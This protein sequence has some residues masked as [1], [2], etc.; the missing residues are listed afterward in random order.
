[1]TGED[2]SGEPPSEDD[3][4]TSDTKGLRKNAEPRRYFIP[5]SEVPPVAFDSVRRYFCYPGQGLE[6][7]VIWFIRDCDKENASA[8]QDKYKHLTRYSVTLVKLL[9]TNQLIAVGE[10]AN[11]NKSILPAFFWLDNL[12][13]CFGSNYD[14]VATIVNEK[15]SEKIRIVTIYDPTTAPGLPDQPHNNTDSLEI[16][17]NESE[18][19]KIRNPRGAG[20]K[21]K[22]DWDEA[23]DLFIEQIALTLDRPLSLESAYKDYFIPL[24]ISKSI[25][26]VSDKA[27]KERL[28]EK[29]PLLYHNIKVNRNKVS[30]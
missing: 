25:E 10:N 22:I 23:L 7:S 4:Q 8:Y 19:V 28:L 17:Q 1:M 20:A 21:P 30:K 12:H 13:I 26:L 29:F 16:S 24:C 15:R 6:A 5:W 9:Q 18:K 27:F 11:G 2:K 3:E 14:Y